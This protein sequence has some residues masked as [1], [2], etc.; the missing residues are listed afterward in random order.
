MTGRS[1][2]K[3]RHGGPADKQ[4]GM[5]WS[6]T[7]ILAATG[8]KIVRDGRKARFGEIVTDS[9]KVRR[10][11]V[12]LALKGERHDGH[13][14]VGAAVQG[15]AA[16]V[17]VQ[18][19]LPAKIVGQATAVQVADTLVALG[20]LAH[21]R[22]QKIAPKVLAVTGS[23]GKTTT[24]EM[25]AAILEEA[26]LDGLPLRGRVLKTEG[27]F[28]NLVGLPLT[29]L[30]LRRQHRVAVVSGTNHPGEIQRLAEIADRTWA[31]LPQS[32]RRIW[33]D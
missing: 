24:K 18:R 23:N 29:L 6:K 14:F 8:G 3:R 33:K 31:S 30:G 9:T 4:R 1:L 20:D 13:R 22:R 2:A 17:I 15:G 32:E 26:T 19:A 12:F 25:I 10:G 27:N 5:G 21:H 7:E 28:N 16:C 11:A